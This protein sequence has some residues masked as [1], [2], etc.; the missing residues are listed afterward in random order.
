MINKISVV[1]IVLVLSAGP[2]AAQESFNVER[3]MTEV[4]QENLKRIG[5]E[6]QQQI[7]STLRKQA[8]DLAAIREAGFRVNSQ[9]KLE[10]I[11]SGG[12]IPITSSSGGNV[13]LSS[14][15][16]ELDSDMFSEDESFDEE[17]SNEV[18]DYG[19]AMA[20]QLPKLKGILTNSVLFEINGEKVRF[21]QGETLPGGFEVDTVGSDS[22]SLI[23]PNGNKKTVFM[24]W[25]YSPSGLLG[26]QNNSMMV[27]SAQGEF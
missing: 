17:S 4:R 16:V 13:A 23:L 19:G 5:E 20:G 10:L 3:S 6:R 11:D 14:A 18:G 24:D 7:T 12:F 1:F 27:E 26:R 21:S 2:A 8:E 22:V 15:G 9:G 25:S